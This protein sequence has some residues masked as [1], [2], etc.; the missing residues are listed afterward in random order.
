MHI[1]QDV[2]EVCV[3]TLVWLYREFPIPISKLGLDNK[4]QIDPVTCENDSQ[5]SVS[6]GYPRSAKP[7]KWNFNNM[8]REK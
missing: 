4:L 5:I 3:K 1:I 6:F 7:T 8:R 2:L